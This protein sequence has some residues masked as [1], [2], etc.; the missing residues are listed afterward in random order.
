MQEKVEESRITFLN[1]CHLRMKRD[2]V[3]TVELAYLL[4][5]RFHKGQLRKE[6]DEAGNFL[7][8]FVHVRRVAISLLELGV[9]DCATICSALLHDMV[10]D[11]DDSQLAVMLLNN[12]FSNYPE[13]EEAVRALT[14]IPKEGYLDRLSRAINEPHGDIVLLVKMADRLDNLNSLPVD[15]EVFCKKQIKETKE[16][17]IP[18]F[19]QEGRV[20]R[21]EFRTAYNDLLM[22]LH[23]KVA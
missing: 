17:M 19:T 6:K 22:K 2:D 9:S 15:D 23:A 16:K 21:P 14:K 4:S 8:Y 20:L 1:R 3:R 13:I 7:R 10:E 18:I 5:K 12:S 11:T